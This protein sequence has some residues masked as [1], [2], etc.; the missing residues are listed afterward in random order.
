MSQDKV[1]Y[2]LALASRAAR[3]VRSEALVAQS[4]FR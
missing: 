2:S 1:Q 4:S 3:E